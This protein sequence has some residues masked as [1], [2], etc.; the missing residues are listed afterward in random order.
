MA[1]MGYGGIIAIVV[2]MAL[3]FSYSIPGIRDGV[4]GGIGLVFGPLAGSVPF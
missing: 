3:I 2:A 1:K 4:G